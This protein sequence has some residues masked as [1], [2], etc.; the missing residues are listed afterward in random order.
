MPHTNRRKKT[1]GSTPKREEKKPLIVHT[2]RKEVADEEGWTHIV[3]TPRTRSATLKSKSKVSALHGG[4]FEINGVSYINRTLEELKADYEYWRKAWEE[5]DACKDLVEKIQAGKK[6]KRSV[7]NVVLLGLG[8]LQSSRREG[9]RSSAT[10]L[11]ALQTII[12][13]LGGD[14]KLVAQD[15]Q[16]TDVDKE[17][18]TSFGYTVVE[19]PKAFTSIGQGSMVYAIHCY[20][21]VYK[22][23]SEAPRPVLLI[24]TDVGNFGRFDTSDTI[25]D[26]AK[27]LEDMVD[28]CEQLDFPQI[29]HDFSDTKIYWRGTFQPDTTK[30]EESQPDTL[31]PEESKGENAKIEAPQP[32]AAQPETPETETKA[33]EAAVSQSQAV[34]QP[35]SDESKET[36]PPKSESAAS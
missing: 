9:R 10:Q 35:I 36:E 6:G 17:F 26:V 31:L 30:A 22:A 16:F 25:E 3:D 7:D 21:R 33:P 12:Q 20:A 1:A 15:P 34:E 5:S 32:E 29:R 13:V 2:K 4:D 23:V 19:D 24:G 27:S 28:G 8:S 18:L 14:V 11:A